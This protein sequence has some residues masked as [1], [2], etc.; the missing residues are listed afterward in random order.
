MCASLPFLFPSNV[1]ALLKNNTTLLTN[2]S[3]YIWQPKV[4]HFRITACLRLAVTI[5]F[6]CSTPG[7]SRDTQ[8]RVPRATSKW[9]LKIPEET[10]Q[11]LG[12]LHQCSVTHTVKCF[13]TFRRCLLFKYIVQTVFTGP[14][15]CLVH[16]T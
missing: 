4:Y 5:G 12:S 16:T 6:I 9:L 15:L 2:L 7:C 11:P 14:H 8:S 1:I 10:L 3:P 13:L